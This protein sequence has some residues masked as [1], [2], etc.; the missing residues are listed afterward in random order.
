MQTPGDTEDSWQ[1]AVAKR[2]TAGRAWA[3]HELTRFNVLLALIITLI[4]EP[5]ATTLFAS[6]SVFIDK[7]QKPDVNPKKQKTEPAPDKPKESRLT[8]IIRAVFK[9]FASLT[10]ILVGTQLS[11]RVKLLRCLWPSSKPEAD[12]WLAIRVAVL[13]ACAHMCLRFITKFEEPMIK[14]SQKLTFQGSV[15]SLPNEALDF[16]LET[17]RCDLEPGSIRELK[18]DL[19]NMSSREQQSKHACLVISEWDGAIRPTTFKDERVHKSNRDLAKGQ[20]CSKPCAFAKVAA[21][22]VCNYFSYAYKALGN[23]DVKNRASPQMVDAAHASSQKSTYS[24][25]NHVGSAK[26]S[27]VEKR[28]RELSRNPDLPCNLPCDTSRS[29][30]KQK[31]IKE[32]DDFNNERKAELCELH[33]AKVMAKRSVDYR[34]KQAALQKEAQK[35][36][37]TRPWG[38]GDQSYPLTVEDISKCM[39]KFKN[40]DDAAAFMLQVGM[41][42]QEINRIF[43]LSKYHGPERVARSALRHVFETRTPPGPPATDSTWHLAL[44]IFAEVGKEE[45][46]FQK[47]FGFCPLANASVKTDTEKIAAAIQRQLRNLPKEELWST[48]LLFSGGTG[49]RDDVANIFVW[50]AGDSFSFV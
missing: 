6:T 4:L 34:I 24:K 13:A 3:T 16:I 29:R 20:S 27:W 17:P 42:H 8:P 21:G 18:Q 10:E 47:H 12:M 5:I 39:A 28:T 22:H 43:S 2:L 50:V 33:R 46:C 31:A 11:D 37:T 48:Q 45:S 32:W 41:P 23:R 9:A 15:P 26:L 38:F 35:P 14:L 36:E 19:E 7:K 30:L 1:A 44:K 49:G 25:P 40:K